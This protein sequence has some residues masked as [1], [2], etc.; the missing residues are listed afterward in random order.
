MENHLEFV[1][2]LGLL[3]LAANVGGMISKKLKQPAVL[4]QIIAGIILGFG[5]M[6]Q[7]E[8]ITQ[9]SEIGVIFLMF[10]AGLETD[11]KELKATGKSSATVALMGVVVPMLFVST[12]AYY[13]TGNLISSLI[14]GLISIATSVSIS[15]QTLKE[16]GFLRS[17]QGVGILG[18]AII[19]D[20]IGVI[21][22]TLII[23]LAGPGE[24]VS[25]SQVLIK[26]VL[27]FVIIIITGAIIIKVLSKLSL[28]TNIKDKVVG[29]AL[30]TCLL[31]AFMSEELGVAAI[32]G[33][34]FAGVIF[35]LTPYGHKIAHDTQIMSDIFFT[36]IFFAAIGL[37]VEMSAIG[38]G[39]VFSLI[40]L[41]LGIVGK[42]GG[43]GVGARLTG[44]NKERSIQIGIGM[45]P[46]AE[47][48][49]IIANL[50][51][52]LSLISTT[53]FSSA[54]VL[55]I[56]TT[57]ITPPLLKWSFRNEEPVLY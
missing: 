46:R 23:G 39:I 33:A 52:Q 20:I 16:I 31:L 36:P 44:F 54:I 51:L 50:G 56:A 48:A 3:L 42:I 49:L 12:T 8:F 21:L 41:A 13:I 6:E 34:Y 38:Q 19:D 40:M 4:G 11:V 30:V 9:I 55:V 15:V 57:L 5:F 7:T 24:T 43:C 53:E 25:I 35:S 17:K 10:I 32:T 29:F 26:I 45:V 22:L 37:G 1:I 28:N 18:A 27:V 47:V 2:H 14:V